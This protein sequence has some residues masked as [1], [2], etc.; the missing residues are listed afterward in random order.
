MSK[1]CR[2][3]PLKV[4]IVAEHASSV[5][6]GEALIP[7]Q[8]FKHLRRLNVD[9]HLLIH[10]RTRQELSEAFQ[11]DIARLHFVLDSR[12]NIWC[13]KIGRFIPDRLAVFTVGA[14]S[15][16]ETQVRQRR[17][18][19]ALVR[20]HKFDVIHEPIPVS[21][22]LPS[23]MFG[24]SVPVII[25]PMNGG[26]DYPPHYNSAKPYERAII[27][28]LRWS[29]TFWNWLVPGKPRAALILVAN[30]RTYDALPP[31]V[32]A[33]RILEF[34][35]NGVDLDRFRAEPRRTEHENIN[36]IYVGRLV[37]WKR[38][39]LLIECCSKLIGKLNFQVHIV[40]DGP[41]RAALERQ[42]QQMLLTNHV[43]FHG[44]TA[45]ASAAQL[46]RDSDLMVLPS[47]RECGGAVVLE[48]MASGIPVIAT[49]WGGPADYIAPDTGKLIPPGTPDEYVEKLANAILWMARNPEARV[50]MGQAGRDRVEALYDWRVKATALLKFYEDVVS[51]KGP[52]FKR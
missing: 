45:Q 11:D 14:F 42:V 26:M 30:K 34:V 49:K 21:P 24:L 18:A 41:L 43:K 1:T 9:V 48:A 23:M 46:L 25:G 33:N 5:F 40:G 44:W 2:G 52:Q 19:K 8:Y 12:I 37:D 47:M 17:L 31:N 50:K 51:T 16:F 36:I 35:E 3:T 20:E 39:D 22:K 15:H 28:L 29:S 27:S 13:Y 4:L 6:G 10:E 38:V 32:K 7:Y